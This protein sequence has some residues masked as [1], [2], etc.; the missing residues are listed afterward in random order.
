MC[1]VYNILGVMNFFGYIW[2]NRIL[3]VEF[4]LKGHLAKK[5]AFGTSHVG[6]VVKNPPAK[7]VDVRDVGWIPGL[8]RSS[9]E[10]H[11][12]PLQYSCLENFMDRGAWRAI[13]HGVAHNWT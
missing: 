5:F 13:V 6:L 2:A 3:E 12:N 10:G 9:G 1:L 11:G 7:A 4:Q 8:G